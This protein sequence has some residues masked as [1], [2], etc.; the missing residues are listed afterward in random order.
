[1]SSDVSFEDIQLTIKKTL[2]RQANIY[3]RKA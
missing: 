1:M 2:Q 3:N